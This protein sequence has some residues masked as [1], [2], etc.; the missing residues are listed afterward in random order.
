MKPYSLEPVRCRYCKGS[1]INVMNDTGWC[2][3]IE[4]DETVSYYHSECVQVYDGIVTFWV[5]LNW[6]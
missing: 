2:Y 4:D 6:S 5:V 1:I 3:I